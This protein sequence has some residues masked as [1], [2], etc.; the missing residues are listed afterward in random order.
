VPRRS[1]LRLRVTRC[2]LGQLPQ[3]VAHNAGVAGSSPAPAID[4]PITYGWLAHVV[5]RRST[6]NGI[7]C[8]G[9]LILNR[10]DALPFVAIPLTRHE[11]SIHFQHEHC[12]RVAKLP[13]DEFRGRAAARGAHCVAMSLVAQL[14]TVTP[15]DV[16]AIGASLV[17]RAKEGDVSASRLVLDRVLGTSPV[18]TWESRAE[19]EGRAA[20][21]KYFKLA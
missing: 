4:E 1:A 7:G 20:L 3:V 16:R 15:D 12:I 8:P 5:S 13:S 2:V 21:E 11:V 9:F 6:R 17:A 19:L 10:A 18:A 14:N